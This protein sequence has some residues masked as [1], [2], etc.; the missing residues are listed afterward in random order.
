MI[1]NISAREHSSAETEYNIEL[2][3]V[4]QISRYT[5]NDVIDEILKCCMDNKQ[6]GYEDGV[7]GKESIWVQFQPT[8]QVGG[9]CMFVDLQHPSLQ[10][11]VFL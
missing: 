8:V 4:K 1:Q 10:V 9:L 2:N 5:G 7:T 3:W 6:G 11:S